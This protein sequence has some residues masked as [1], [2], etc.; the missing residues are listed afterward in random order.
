MSKRVETF[1]KFSKLSVCELA[2]IQLK[3][4]LLKKR[5]KKRIAQNRKLSA[6]TLATDLAI[7]GSVGR[8]QGRKRLICCL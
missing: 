2:E 6:C 4:L 8:K 5:E 7:T 3:L 1:H